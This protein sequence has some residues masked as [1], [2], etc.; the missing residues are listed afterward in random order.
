MSWF[1]SPPAL[2]YNIN[3]IQSSIVEVSEE[4]C[5]R[6]VPMPRVKAEGVA[7]YSGGGTGKIHG[8][9]TRETPATGKRSPGC[10]SV[11]TRRAQPVH[12]QLSGM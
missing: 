3:A 9:P 8:L 12:T 2:P 7:V 4:I 6:P 11:R 1:E 10:G 5:R